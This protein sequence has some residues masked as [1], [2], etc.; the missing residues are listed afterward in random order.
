MAARSFLLGQGFSIADCNLAGVL[1][2]SWFKG[3]DLSAV[4]WVKA[5]MERCMTRP[6]ALA[7][8]RLREG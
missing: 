4:P 2:G 5:W 3:Y 6:A 8:R 1:Y 7:A